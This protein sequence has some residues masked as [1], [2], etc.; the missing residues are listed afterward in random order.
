MIEKTTKAHLQ[1]I[2]QI[3]RRPFTSTVFAVRVLMNAIQI[4]RY[5][6]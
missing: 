5:A 4:E 6:E 3:I 2:R 1:V